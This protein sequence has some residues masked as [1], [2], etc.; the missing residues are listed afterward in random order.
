MVL[1]SSMVTLVVAEA[2]S[3]TAPVQLTNCQPLAG[4]AVILTTV[5]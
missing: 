3:T 1:S 2:G 5:S 4:V